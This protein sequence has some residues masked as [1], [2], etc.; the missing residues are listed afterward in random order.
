[1]LEPASYQQVTDWLDARTAEPAPEDLATARSP[2]RVL[3]GG[4]SV[5]D[6]YPAAPTAAADGYALLS[7]A[8]LGASDYNPLPLRIGST[9]EPVVSGQR[10][11]GN[12]D[13]VIRH[14]DTD[15]RGEVLDVYAPVASGDN[16]IPVGR[17]ARRGETLFG[18]GHVLRPADVA[19][20]IELG[21]ATVPVVRR[22]R[23]GVV[24]VRG[25]V[26]DACGPMVR[27]LVAMDGGAG[28]QPVH[29]DETGLAAA[30]AG[31]DDDL[32]IVIGGSGTGG[33]DH[34]A[35]ALREAGEVTF[36]GVAISPG[37]TV[38][39]GV[40]R[41]RPVIVLP[42]PPLAA[43]CAYDMLAGRAVRQLAGRSPRLPYGTR[44]GTLVRKIASGLGRLECCRVRVIGERVEPI[45]V[46]DNRTLSTAVRADG[47]VLVPEQSEGFAEGDEVTVYLYAQRY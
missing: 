28:D 20:L 16:V 1:M 8:T 30:L 31:R 3:A 22:P 36:R 43:L 15:R 35:E 27:A 21:V 6:D 37:E 33:N 24:V 19:L 5:P 44:R 17:E 41:G 9:V 39:L 11:P 25:D 10:L 2:G 47:F 4:V 42:G 29:P 32:L 7:Q 38:T 40:V 23:I 46:A 18:A 14:E 12:T 45:A 26:P 34:A 13:A